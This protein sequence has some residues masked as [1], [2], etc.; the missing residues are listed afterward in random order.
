MTIE[1]IIK[2]LVVKETKEIP[3]KS[4]DLFYLAKLA[5]I[6][7]SLEQISLMQILMKYQLEGRYP[8]TYPTSPLIKL[9]KEY[10]NNTKILKECFNKML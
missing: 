2:A 5:N 3:P 6:E 9:T 8:Y 1:K 10:L 4:H 7:I